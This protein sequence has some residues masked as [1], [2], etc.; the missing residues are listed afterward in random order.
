MSRAVLRKLKG[1]QM[2]T[3][4]HSRYSR[5]GNCHTGIATRAT[6]ILTASALMT[7]AA[8]SFGIGAQE[9][10]AAVQ[11]NITWN[12]P[13]QYVFQVPLGAKNLRATV[14]GADGGAGGSSGSSLGGQGGSGTQLTDFALDNIQPG[15]HLFITVGAAGQNASNDSVSGAAGGSGWSNGGSGREG[16]TGLFEGRGGGGGGGSSALLVGSDVIAVAGGGG[17]GGGSARAGT[18]PSYSNYWG[19]AGGTVT[20]AY[21]RGQNGYG[22]SGV[23]GAFA[24]NGDNP[25]GGTGEYATQLLE[26][27]GGGGGG[28]GYSSG[29]QGGGAV[30][31]SL[32][33]KGGGGGGA[34]DHYSNPVY[35][36]AQPDMDNIVSGIQADGAVILTFDIEIDTE[37][38]VTPPSP[39]YVGQQM[40]YEV[41]VT[42]ADGALA[43]GE[44]CIAF[45]EGSSCTSDLTNAGGTATATITRTAEVGDI[46]VKTL[47]AFFTPTDPKYG[48]GTADFQVETL[49]IPSATVVAAPSS[50]FAMESVS[51]G[52]TVTPERGYAPDGTVTFR[53]FNDQGTVIEKTVPVDA[54]GEAVYEV[55]EGLPAGDYQVSATYAHA[56]AAVL[57]STSPSAPLTVSKRGVVLSAVADPTPSSQ[58]GDPLAVTVSASSD[59][60]V[61][62]TGTVKVGYVRAGAKTVLAELPLDDGSVVFPSVQDWP[63]GDD[64]QYQVWYAGDDRHSESSQ[65]FD[66]ALTEVPSTLDLSQV[67]TSSFV[68]EQLTFDVVAG[69]GSEYVTE[70]DGELSA[71]RDTNVAIDSKPVTG[72]IPQSVSFTASFGEAGTHPVSFQYED[73]RD[74]IASATQGVSHTVLKH[75]TSVEIPGDLSLAYGDDVSV[76]ATV[77]PTDGTH[78]PSVPSGGAKFT[79]LQDTEQ[80]CDPIEQAL[81]QGSVAFAQAFDDCQLAPGQYSLLVSYDGDRAHEPASASTLMTIAAND[82]ALTLSAGSPRVKAGQ[83]IDLEATL[84]VEGP[85]KPNGTIEFLLDDQ[86]VGT[87]SVGGNSMA[88]LLRT[89]IAAPGESDATSPTRVQY[90]LESGIDHVTEGA[91]FTARYTD[92]GGQ[93]ANALSENVTVAV[94]AVP[95]E[96]KISGPDTASLREQSQFTA[97]VSNSVES[98][99]APTGKVQFFTY[100]KGADASTAKPLGAPVALN[101]KASAQLHISDLP[102]GTHMVYAKYL[103]SETHESSASAPAQLVVV[104]AK[105]S[106]LANTGSTVAASLG[107]A[108]MLVGAGYILQRR[109]HESAGARRSSHSR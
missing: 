76:Q 45:P 30:G 62:P 20:S 53:V 103:G 109:R 34:G 106:A 39:G 58:Y 48:E 57:P 67:P 37:L 92:D 8:A 46:G 10:Q 3:K 71:V 72:T 29:G 27:G 36:N 59:G 68:D 40:T 5:A 47:T 65:S 16:S 13:G 81:D 94:D 77:T 96:V 49:A 85:G 12:T 69:L 79:I 102:L 21:G 90:R 98:N 100:S 97:Q 66:H 6:A 84:S 22:D 74:F 82:S 2:I 9:A 86:V 93:V 44:V 32:T 107:L 11:Q 60:L 19:G 28:A 56:D 1:R 83:P 88:A 70:L 7:V 38:A 15:D 63:W 64:V 41:Q 33:V 25:D 73:N 75:Q 80:A 55:A 26:S 14:R 50:A 78:V 51:L 105:S 43:A 17:G 24:G 95:T 52:S 108:M 31:A 87:A 4:E 23:G 99:L 54:S 91:V 101:D 42:H 61:K 18:W 89:L 104:P 35:A